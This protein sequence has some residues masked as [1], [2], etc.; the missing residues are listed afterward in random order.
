MIRNTFFSF[1]FFFTYFCT[2]QIDMDGF[3]TKLKSSGNSKFMS[4]HWSNCG[5]LICFSFGCQTL[6]KLQWSESV[7]IICQS[8]PRQPVAE[9]GASIS[10]HSFSSI[11]LSVFK[12]WQTQ[13]LYLAAQKGVFLSANYT[14]CGFQLFE[15]K[16]DNLALDCFFEIFRS[17]MSE[18]CTLAALLQFTLY[19]KF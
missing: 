12:I 4:E 17:Q 7:R 3:F 9:Q 11:K 18:N 1:F 6:S 13:L 14:L 15:K 16:Q 8:L 19:V 10:P 5:S 2:F